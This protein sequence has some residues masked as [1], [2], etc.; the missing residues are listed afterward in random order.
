MLNEYIYEGIDKGM[1]QVELEMRSQEEIINREI[2]ALKERKR[3][4]ESE[5]VAMLSL[6]V[7][8]ENNKKAVIELDKEILELEQKL[9]I[10][11]LDNS[12]LDVQERENLVALTEGEQALASLKEEAAPIKSI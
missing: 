7:V 5:T 9:T 11:R 8:Q 2:D 1:E 12:Y 3:I 6:S 10:I 4:L